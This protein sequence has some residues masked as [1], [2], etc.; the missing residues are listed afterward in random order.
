MQDKSER[1]SQSL[2]S[3]CGNMTL[4]SDERSRLTSALLYTSNEHFFSIVK[5]C[6]KNIPTSAFALLRPQYE[7]YT[8]GIWVQYCAT[9]PQVES[10]LNGKN[11]PRGNADI[12]RDLDGVEGIDGNALNNLNEV[13]WKKGCDYTH[14]GGI[15]ASWHIGRS[16]IGSQYNRKE[17]NGLCQVSCSISL[18]NSIDLAKLCNS[19]NTV[20]KL[21]NKYKKV[22]K[23]YMPVPTD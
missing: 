16:S 2:S 23:I 4:V 20:V 1:W 9:D 11:F 6:S 17:I 19:P 15:Q 10:I 14:G 18:S 7:A 5:L 3:L 21:A 22:F 8:R 13:V 12:L